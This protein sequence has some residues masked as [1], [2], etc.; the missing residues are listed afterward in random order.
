MLLGFFGSFLSRIYRN[1]VK[2]LLYCLLTFLLAIV[3]N[4]IST[5][6]AISKYGVD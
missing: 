4:T 1:K 6:Q 2:F 5:K 3:A